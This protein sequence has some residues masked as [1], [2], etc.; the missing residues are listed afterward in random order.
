MHMIVHIA[1]DFQVSAVADVG[2]G[3]EEFQVCGRRPHHRRRQSPHKQPSLGGSG[4]MLP[5]NKC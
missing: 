2:F 3:K 1:G 5:Q 4:G